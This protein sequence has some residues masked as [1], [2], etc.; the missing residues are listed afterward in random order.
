MAKSSQDKQICTMQYSNSCKKR[1]GE[2]LLKDFYS[3]I[4]DKMYAN[5]KIHICKECIKDYVYDENGKV[6]LDKF[7]EILMMI[8]APFYSQDFQTA[9]D[10]KSDTIGVYMRSIYLNHKGEGFL[11]G[12]KVYEESK[13]SNTNNDTEKELVLSQKELK[14]LREKWGDGYDNDIY[15][16]FE[17]KYRFLKNNYPEKTSMH[18]EALLKYIRYSVMEEIAIASSDPK[19]AKSWGELANKAATAAKINP[20]QLSK[21]DLTGGLSTFG[22]LIRAIEQH[23]DIVPILPEFKEKPKDKVDFTIWCY[24]N[25]VR[26]LKGMPLCDY[27]EVYDFYEKRKQEYLQHNVDD[28][29]FENE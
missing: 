6:K 25:Y 14:K 26:D 29:V 7:K 12:E 13:Y 28:K 16:A 15:L 22:E 18:T 27:K 3:A 17:K 19:D 1:K 10:K 11:N 21:A 8:N 9:C 2:W 24:I 23:E 5:G 4:N 20:S